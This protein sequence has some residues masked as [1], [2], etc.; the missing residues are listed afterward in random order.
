MNRINALSLSLI[1]VSAMNVFAG[2]RKA[3]T[4]T[5]HVYVYKGQNYKCVGSFSNVYAAHQ[6]AEKERG[7]K[8]L[9]PDAVEIEI[10]ELE[11]GSTVVFE[12][13]DLRCRT[14]EQ[15]GT[16][17]SEQAAVKAAEAARKEGANIEIVVR[18][19]PAK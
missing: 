14:V 12:L 13:W 9:R 16:F 2:E 4:E 17:C 15:L 8:Q 18:R 3:G 7:D 10:G 19:I 6:A 1:I 5:Y 11:S